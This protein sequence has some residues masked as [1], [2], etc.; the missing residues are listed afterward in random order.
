MGIQF[1]TSVCQKRR[2][3]CWMWELEKR[4]TGSRERMDAHAHALAATPT[5]TGITAVAVSQIERGG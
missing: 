4:E 2:L 1:G 3:L 5:Y